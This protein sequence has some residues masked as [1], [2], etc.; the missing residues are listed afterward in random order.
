MNKNIFF[1]FIFIFWI[2]GTIT[3]WIHYNVI[4][5]PISSIYDAQYIMD[6]SQTK[7]LVEFADAIMVVKVEKE[8]WN[9]YLWSLPATQYS[10]KVL[11][12]ISGNVEENIIIEQE[13]G[14]E[15]G[16]LYISQWDAMRGKIEWNNGLL[17]IWWYYIIATKYN[18]DK[19]WY[20]IISHENGTKTLKKDKNTIAEEIK[21]DTKI[22]EIKDYI[23]G[24]KK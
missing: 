11:E 16:I 10:A 19:K 15:N 20:T 17:E 4:K 6:F 23:Q 24:K 22:K 9:E 7:N 8:V 21:N 12:A 13:A 2:I 5:F 14:Y 18:M 3:T 1:S